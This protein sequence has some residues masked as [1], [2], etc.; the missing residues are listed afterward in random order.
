M[1]WHNVFEHNSEAVVSNFS[2]SHPEDVKVLESP[3]Y[4]GEVS[5]LLKIP[6]TAT[7]TARGTLKCAKL[8]NV[9]YKNLD[10]KS[11]EREL[12]HVTFYCRF[13]RVLA[14]CMD[15]L[16]E[17]ISQYEGHFFWSKIIFSR[18]NCENIDVVTSDIRVIVSAT[19]TFSDETLYKNCSFYLLSI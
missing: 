12:T 9:R 6:R 16:K 17:R 11:T 7:V 5:L 8:D 3:H 14:P 19:G 4:F 13:E 1:Y 2:D 10:I 15:V 18:D